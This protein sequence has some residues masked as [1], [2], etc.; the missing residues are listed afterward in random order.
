M[1]GTSEGVSQS[2]NREQRKRGQE[3]GLPLGAQLKKVPKNWVKFDIKTRSVCL[4]KPCWSRGKGAR[5][6]VDHVSRLQF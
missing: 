3:P 1:S 5:S 6:N 2:E 4:A